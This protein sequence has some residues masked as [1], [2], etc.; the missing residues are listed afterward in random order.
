MPIS[1]VLFLHTPLGTLIENNFQP[2]KFAEARGIEKKNI[3]CK[4]VWVWKNAT[5]DAASALSKNLYCMNSKTG[6]AL[7]TARGH[8]SCGMGIRKPSK[9]L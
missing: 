1:I 3:K 9:D 7:A 8:F 2:Q 5:C 6:L 4:N